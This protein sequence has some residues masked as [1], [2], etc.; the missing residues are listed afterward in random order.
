MLRFLSK[1]AQWPIILATMARRR[2]LRDFERGVSKKHREFKGCVCVCHQI[3]TQ[4]NTLWEILK[5]RLRQCFPPP[6]TT[7]NDGISCGRIVLHPSNR[8]PDTCRIYAKANWCCSGGSRWPNTL[9]IQFM[10]TF[11]LIWQLPV[12]G[13]CTRN[14]LFSV[15]H[16]N[17]RWKITVDSKA[18][19]QCLFH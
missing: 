5:R 15:S 16:T 17:T 18:L 6:T 14:A 1:N 2:D 13:W 11:P 9:L 3:S 7:P 19:C 8:V 12:C 10:L 4:L